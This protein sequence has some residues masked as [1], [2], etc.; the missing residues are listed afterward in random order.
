MRK[1]IKEELEEKY[2]RAVLIND[3]NL[4]IYTDNEYVENRV[5][6]KVRYVDKNKIVEQLVTSLTKEEFLTKREELLEVNEAHTAIAVYKED[7][8]SLILDRLYMLDTHYFAIADFMDIQYNMYF[9]E[10]NNTMTDELV[11]K[12]GSKHG[13]Y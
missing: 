12:R 6:L 8:D 13:K 5:D 7:K 10:H 2:L 4:A 11:K 9:P 1:N 3:E